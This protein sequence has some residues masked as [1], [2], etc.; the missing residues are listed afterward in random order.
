MIDLNKSYGIDKET[1]HNSKL[2]KLIKTC[3]NLF[4]LIIAIL[5]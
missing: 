1:K 3:R 4:Y 2:R 5:I